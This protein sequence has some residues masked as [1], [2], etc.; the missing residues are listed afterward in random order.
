MPHPIETADLSLRYGRTEAVRHLTME[1]PAGSVYALIGPNGAGKTTTIKA[2]MNLLRPSSGRASVLGLDSRRVGPAVLQRIG[3]VSENQELPL[4]MTASDLLAYCAPFYPSWD[5]AFASALAKQ[6]ALPMDRPLKACSRGTRMKAA[7]VASLAYHP[8]LIV[9]DEPFAGLDALVRE[10]FTQGILEVAGGDRPWTV[11]ISSH[12]I[13]E[14][15][16]LADWIGVINEGR[17]ELAETASSLLARFRR[18][19]VATGSDAAVP[20][21]PP[22][23]WLL[24]EASAHAVRFVESAYSDDDCGARVRKAIPAA[25]DILVT[26]MSLR[27]IFIVLARVFRLADSQGG[28]R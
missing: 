7:L 26:P 8:E 22:A 25:R 3:Y 20:S 21:P 9:L 14:V 27:E 17:L 18:I 4:W 16:R 15:E 11:F 5:R 12:D 24:V 23:S 10:E 2:L 28:S 1:V 6:L 13:D 19:E